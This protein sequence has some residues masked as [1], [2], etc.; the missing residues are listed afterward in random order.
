LET[1]HDFDNIGLNS[2]MGRLCYVMGMGGAKEKN[3]M[4]ELKG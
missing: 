4:R 2:V 3:A 1:I